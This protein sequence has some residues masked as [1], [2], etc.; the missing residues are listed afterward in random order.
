VASGESRN[1]IGRGE[2][3]VGLLSKILAGKAANSGR[4]RAK[5]GGVSLHPSK[6]TSVVSAKPEGRI[7]SLELQRIMSLERIEDYTPFDVS[8]IETTECKIQLREV[9]LKALSA[10]RQMQGGF[11][12]V[13]VGHGKT[14]ISL[15]AAQAMG[16]KHAIL[17]LPAPT[18]HQIEAE[19]ERL[20]ES[21]NFTS[22]EITTYGMLSRDPEGCPL[23]PL[24]CGHAAK[25]C[26]L[27][28]DEAH[29]IKRKQSARTKRVLRFVKANQD[30][31]VVCLSGTMTTKSLLEYHHLMLL[32]LREK[33]PLPLKGRELRSWADSLDVEGECKWNSLMDMEPLLKAYDPNIVKLRGA[34]QSVRKKR[35]RE[36]FQ[37]HLRGSAGVV[38]TEESALGVSLLIGSHKKVKA[39]SDD[40]KEI[41]KMVKEQG[42]S[43]DG[44]NEYADASEIARALNQLSLGFFYRWV[45][46]NGKID[47]EW[48]ETRSE[49]NRLVRWEL[50]YSA[51]EGYDSPALVERRVREW[52][53]HGKSN[54][55]TNALANW[56]QHSYKKEPPTEAVWLD[57]SVIRWAC[58]YA[59]ANNLAIWYRSKAVANKIEEVCPSCRVYRTGDLVP[60]FDEERPADEQWHFAA[61]STSAHKEGLNL[62]HYDR[63]LII[64][65]PSSGAVWEQV[66]GRLHRPLQPSDEV[67]FEVLTHT[68]RLRRCLE[69]GITDARYIEATTGQKQKL[70]SATYYKV[71]DKRV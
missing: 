27:I 32:C 49:W 1:G 40:L 35:A 69:T 41:I 62:Q 52:I 5:T 51:E 42:I 6:R 24:M 61:Y 26:V 37:K 4:V 70:C 64:E 11:F 47:L 66:M 28:F 16:K 10:L 25:D 2:I 68:E 33:I 67:Y 46:P 48:L 65:L 13:G 19:C 9:Q 21:F 18:K 20:R 63:A 7:L 43:P 38:C 39:F 55:L 60:S 54:H 53:E 57:D 58:D 8:P 23:T 29:R 12:P 59:K 44:E 56:D 50:S 17:V 3:I 22:I 31:A 30:I 15:L 14:Y 71:N 45:W 36:A 34:S